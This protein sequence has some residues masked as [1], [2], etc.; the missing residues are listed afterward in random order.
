MKFKVGDRLVS[1]DTYLGD[2]TIV[3]VLRSVDLYCVFHGNRHVYLDSRFVDRLYTLYTIKDTKKNLL[4]EWVI[5]FTYLILFSIVDF[6]VL[7]ILIFTVFFSG[8]GV[9]IKPKP[10]EVKPITVEH[11]VS[12]DNK[13]LYEFFLAQC[14]AN[15]SLS[16]EEVDECADEKFSDFY[17]AY[18]NSIVGG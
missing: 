17:N 9:T 15:T 10:I 18:N 2:M 7:L 13:M 16:D 3:E 1:K 12:I 6:M 4:D 5:Y 14:S 8:C 11:K